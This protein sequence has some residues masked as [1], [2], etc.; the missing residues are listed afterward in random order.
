MN[1]QFIHIKEGSTMKKWIVALFTL[2]TMMLLIQD[3]FAI[4]AF[5]RRYKIS[6]N[7]CH[8]PFPRLKPYGDEVAAN[9][10]II[11]EEEKERDYVTAGD[12]M[13]WLNK[14]FP[15]AVRFDAFA[16]YDQDAE[17]ERDLQTPW[18]LKLLSG[19]A[20]YKNIGYYFYFYMSE[21]GEIAG[22]ED[23]YIHFNN[24]FNT[25]LD[26]MVGQ[27]QTCDPLMKRELRL[28]YED[29]YIYKMK[30]GESAADLTY[31]RGVMLSY[32]I[33]KT[34]TDIVAM[35]VNGNG[36]GA[37]EN[38]KYDNDNNKNIGLRVKENIG[39]FLGI[40]GFYYMGKE[41]AWI[42]PNPGD[43]E[44]WP[45]FKVENKI[46]YYGPDVTIGV[47]PL[48]FT[49]QYLVRED[50]NPDFFITKPSDKVKG[51]GIVT[52]LVIAPHMD[53]SRYYITLLYNQIDH[54]YTAYNYESATVSGTYLLARNLRVMAE[55][56]R[57]MEN[58]RNRVTIGLV[59]GF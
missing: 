19:G 17:V 25:N 50:T 43:P 13:L 31:D 36:K 26:I 10:F 29:Y 6:C 52:E 4:P 54:D 15:I 20:I 55:Y 42:N 39:D 14:T 27:F 34:A 53:R 58:D 5:A 33:D 23:A 37:A 49:G 2:V 35:F 11:P 9:G 7:T 41:T 30:V 44:P 38:D 12:D 3:A 1:K 46:T 22:I 48:N 51:S 59:S 45:D 24:V 18:G 8:D 32:T 57:D 56:T 21:G 28:T 16:M 47:G 40:G